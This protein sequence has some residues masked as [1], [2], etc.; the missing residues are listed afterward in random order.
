MSH[1]AMRPEAGHGGEPIQIRALIVE[2]EIPVAIDLEEH[3][4]ALGIQVI[5]IATNA[6]EAMRSA[7]ESRPDL[8]F[9]DVRVDGAADG[10]EAWRAIS[11]ELDI[12][13]IIVSGTTDAASLKRIAAMPACKG[14]LRKP[15]KYQDLAIHIRIALRG[16]SFRR[17]E[18]R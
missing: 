10:L 14:V 18:S 9:M 3:L 5:E 15:I 1:K 2:N 17:P 7:R 4:A 13:I 8:I 6:A 11:T 16:T 12:P